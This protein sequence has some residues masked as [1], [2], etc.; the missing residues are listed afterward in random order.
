VAAENTA[1]LSHNSAGIP[2]KR[3]AHIAGFETD[4]V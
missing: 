4:P 2:G 3:G 1:R